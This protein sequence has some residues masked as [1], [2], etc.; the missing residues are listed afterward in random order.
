[1]G[2]IYEEILKIK[3]KGEC[4]AL[5][6]LISTDGST[7]REQGAKMLIRQD[8]GIEGTIGGGLMEKMIREEAEKV[9]E[10]GIPKMV[11]FDLTGGKEGGMICGGV[12]TVYIEA[13]VP[14]SA[15]YIL[16]AGHIGFYLARIAR[17]TDF[18]VVV[19][20][21]RPEYA[22]RERF[23]EADEI[24]AEEYENI[25]KKLA[26]NQSA[27]IVIVTHGH[28]HDQAVL[29]WAVTTK[30]GYIGMIGSRKK[31]RQVFDNLISK[32]FS[33]E[34]IENRVHSPIGL[35]IK[36]ETPGEIAV[37]IMA[38]IIQVRYSEGSDA[39]HACCSD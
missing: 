21:N 35:D 25:F 15:I 3:N 39:K 34:D 33:R 7:P 16:G 36:A 6:T 17:M 37:S 38:E 11:H 10:N 19:C 1:M 26:V 24:M 12:A 31:T 18:R 5:A 8:G 14:K 29:E 9:I 28:T 4:A 27:F 22:N 30:A 20:D 23:P 32:G 2:D 13:I